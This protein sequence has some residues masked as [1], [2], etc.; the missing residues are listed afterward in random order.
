M[1]AN[2]LMDVTAGG[3]VAVGL[4]LSFNTPDLVEFAGLLASTSSSSTANT[5]A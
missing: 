4:G 5:V 1:R 2:R 3:R